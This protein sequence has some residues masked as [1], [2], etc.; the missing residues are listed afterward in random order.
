MTQKYCIFEKQTIK[1]AISVIHKN[2]MRC[3][4]VLND[5]QKLVGVFSEGDVIF[6]LLNGI[7]IHTPLQAVIRPTFFYLKE[8]DMLKAF[9]LV[10]KEGVTLIPI[11]DDDFRL[12]DVITLF[13]VMEHLGYV[14]GE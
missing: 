13:D 14:N 7:D 10:K 8:R 11:I 2:K 3:A 9:R 5:H 12:V 6:S 4:L 1:K